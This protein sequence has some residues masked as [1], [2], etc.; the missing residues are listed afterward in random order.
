MCV[1]VPQKPRRPPPSPKPS[2]PPPPPGKQFQAYKYKK[3]V[4]I[5]SVNSYTYS[6]A[7]NFCYSRGY[8]LVP[9][10][11]LLSKDV[12]GALCF[13]SGLG[14]WVAGAQSGYCPFIDPSGNG[15]PY[16]RN[17]EEKQ[18]VLCFRPSP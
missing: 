2:P 8:S 1:R 6:E 9:Y 4:Y 5:F 12:T 7:A 16:A 17:C 10:R 3:Y 14:C 13:N 11:D 15:G 18:R